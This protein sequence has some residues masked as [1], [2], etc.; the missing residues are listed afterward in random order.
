M[1]QYSNSPHFKKWGLLFYRG[2][3]IFIIFITFFISQIIIYLNSHLNTIKEK[4]VIVYVDIKFKK[5][6]I[7]CKGTGEILKD[8]E[9]STNEK[10]FFTYMCTNCEGN[11][12]IWKKR[13]VTSKQLKGIQDEEN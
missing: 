9:F 4:Q 5:E 3:I 1:F 2:I 10:R 12:Y 11:G 13:T 6:C 7:K 8:Q